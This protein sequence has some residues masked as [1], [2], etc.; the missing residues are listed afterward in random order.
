MIA[1]GYIRRSKQADDEAEDRTVSLDTQ[2]EAILAYAKRAQLTICDWVTHDGMSGTKRSRYAAI[3]AAISKHGA[4]VVI[5]YHRDRLARDSEGIQTQLKAWQRQGVDVHEALGGRIDYKSV[6]GRLTFNI[7]SA[8]DQAWAEKI[9]EKTRDCLATLKARGRRYS[10]IAPLGWRY[11]D[12][13][14]ITDAEE[15]RGLEVIRRCRQSGLG[16]RRTLR[17]LLAGGYNGRRSLKA[18]H[19]AI[20]H[21]DI[22]GGES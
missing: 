16:A 22:E 17:V 9:G 3:Q 12:Q 10:N 4:A 20:K 13:Q 11:V 7:L 2:R 14:L 19:M 15:Q 21:S 18:I 5:V 1:I 8:V 6:D